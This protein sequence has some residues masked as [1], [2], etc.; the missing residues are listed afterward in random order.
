MRLREPMVLMASGTG[1]E[2]PAVDRRLFKEQGAARLSAAFISRSAI[3]VIS[4]SVAAAKRN[5][6]QIRPARSSASTKAVKDS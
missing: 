2:R 1:S 3:S 4:S 5:A 6:L